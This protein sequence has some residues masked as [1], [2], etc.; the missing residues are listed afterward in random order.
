M[1]MRKIGFDVIIPRWEIFN[2]N[3]FYLLGCD[4]DHTIAYLHDNDV[5]IFT[6]R[7]NERLCTRIFGRDRVHVIKKISEIKKMVE[8]NCLIDA[9]YI[10]YSVFRRIRARN[11]K[12][13]KDEI[14]AMREVKDRR[15]LRLLRKAR[16]ITETVLSCIKT[17]GLT[18]SEIKN[19]I[20]VEI[21]KNGVR[22]AFST[23][24]ANSKNARFPHYSGGN[25]A[26]KDYVLIDMGVKYKKY[27]S[28]ITR[29]IG[30]MSAQTKKIYESIKHAVVEISDEAYAGRHIKDFLDVVENIIKRNNLKPFPHSIGHGIGLEVH[31]FP[32]LSKKSKTTLKENSVITI[33]PGQYTNN[34]LRYEEMF[35]VRKNN[36]RPLV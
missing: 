11:M 23:I 7:L 3:F 12:I 24:V 6:S 36:A 32:V 22:E 25:V 9:D 19:K 26:I 21:A 10:P 30:N 33:E 34:G 15:E 28:D 16:R 14:R 2:P 1:K 20:L 27:N 13:M 4:I 8:D 5:E 35:V 17:S 31:E 29:C 18:E